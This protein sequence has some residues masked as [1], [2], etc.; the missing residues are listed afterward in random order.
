[1]IERRSALIYL[2]AFLLLAATLACGQSAPANTTP[3]ASQSANTLAQSD[4]TRS[5][6]VDGQERSYI[7]HIP[8]AYNPSEPTPLVLIFHGYGLNAEDMIRIT[9]FNGQADADGFISV[10]PIGSGSKPAWNGG[11]CCGEAAIKGIDDVGFVRALIE[12]LSRAANIDPKRIYATGFSNGAIMAYRLACELSDQ[13]AA[14]APV[15][16]TQAIETCNPGRPIAL[17]HFHGDADQLNPYNGGY[18][19]GGRV[20]FAPV[21]DTIQF[22]VEK[23]GC[24][25][26]A[27]IDQTGSILH[28][29][30]TPC[31]QGSAVELYH[32]VGGEHAWPGGESVSAE[33]GAPTTEISATP[34]IWAFFKDHP[35]P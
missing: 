15:S 8:T 16:A 10:Y 12:D 1:M 24:P 9:G 11:D 33:I 27:Q 23:N 5:L 35:I 31:A 7:V 18:A 30:Y 25:Q 17:I 20:N 21:D 14:I 4:T 2:C 22:W 13:I 6:S 34:L 28:A 32:I 3:I 19:S 26:E 29:S